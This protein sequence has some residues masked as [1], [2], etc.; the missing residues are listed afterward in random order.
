[1]ILLATPRLLEAMF[2]S[3]SLYLGSTQRDPV[4]MNRSPMDNMHSVSDT[5][6]STRNL[7]P[8]ICDASFLAID[9]PFESAAIKQ[10]NHGLQRPIISN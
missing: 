9:S 8:G 3:F 1:M 10:I 4:W 7:S 6:S 2:S 5:K